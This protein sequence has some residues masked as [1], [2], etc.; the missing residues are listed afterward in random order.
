MRTNRA[1]TWDLRIL[2]A[3]L[4]LWLL[5]ISSLIAQVQ[6]AAQTFTTLYSF[7]GANDGNDPLGTLISSGNRLYGTSSSAG[8]YGTGTIFAIN[9][10][11]TGFTNL[12]SFTALTR[13]SP[14]L[15][16]NADGAMPAA[17]LVLCSNVLYGAAR[18][19]GS[20]GIG[21]LFAINTDGTGF[22]NLHTFV[23]SDGGEPNDLLVSGNSLYGTT[24]V[25]G[26]SG[27]GTVFK[28]NTDGTGFT[29]LFSFTGGTGGQ[30]PQAGLLLVG[31]TLYGTLFT[32]GTRG[33]S[34]PNNGG[35]V[36]KLNIDGTGF[37]NIYNFSGTNDGENPQ[38]RL[39]ISSDTLYGT[40]LDGGATGGYGTVFKLNTNGA[41]FT[42]LYSFTNGN[43]GGGPN[44][45]VVLSGDTLYGTASLGGS[46]SNGTVFAISVDG[47]GFT[48]IYDFSA[49]SSSLPNLTNNDGAL[50]LSGLLLSSYT[51]FGTAAA[52]G[53]SSK[54]TVFSLSFRPE[55][56]MRL[57]KTN[58]ILA[59]P[60]NV[61]GFS[62][63]GFTLQSSSGLS[64]ADV[65]TNFSS[66]PAPIAGENS[67]TD[68][69]SS[70]QMFYR[71]SN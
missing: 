58:L 52:G 17:G 44:A 37:T 31:G 15:G 55:L 35:T 9:K 1:L 41:P 11:G 69:V 30:H 24:R 46:W 48:N 13:I 28:L 39:V 22:T 3:F 50:P 33:G 5:A 26:S 71:L 8:N 20:L 19:G 25:G 4:T 67:V 7:T 16:T 60:T 59:W 10:D 62:Y 45:G 18:W 64:P 66:A 53:D 40:T 12:Y 57:S 6:L 65:W 14:L 49:A 56:E 38:A 70:K 32:G 43:D 42:N 51:L 29:N 36:F 68:I 61:A 63:A 47:T 54:G 23:N 21:T 27:A 34:N 2:R